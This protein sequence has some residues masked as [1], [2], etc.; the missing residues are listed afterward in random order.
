MSMASTSFNPRPLP[1][2]QWCAGISMAAVAAW[3]GAAY[4][5]ELAAPAPLKELLSEH[6][7]LVRYR[8]RDDIN[9][10]LLAFMIDAA[11]AQVRQLAAT[12]GYFSPRTSVTR[13]RRGATD[14]INLTVQPGPRTLVASVDLAVRGPA[15][16]RSPDQVARL[17]RHWSLPPGTPFRQPAWADAKQDALRTLRQRRYA[18]ARIAGSRAAIN[19]DE[20]Q[21]RLHVTYDSGPPFTFGA[22][23]VSGAVRYPETI[24]ANVNPLRV[25]EQYSAARLIEFQRQLLRLPYYSNVV[26][27]MERDPAAAQGAPVHVRVSEFPLQ[28]IRGGIGYTTDT[29]A[30]VSARHSHNSV[31]RPALVLDTELIVEQRRQLGR[32]ELALAPR[33]GGF[34][35]S[36][37]L[38]AE[39]TRLEGIDQRSRRA[40]VQRARHGERRDTL[41]AL[42]YYRD[43]LERLNQAP[44]PADVIIEPGDHQASVA[45]VEKTWRQVD[46]LVFPRSGYV[47][48]AHAGAALKGLLTDQSFVRGYL[49]VQA[50]RPLRPRDLVLLRAELGL[51]ATKG[52]NGAIPASLLFRGGGTDSVRGYAYQSIG[53]LREGTVY[54]ARSLLTASAEYQYWFRP[55]WGAAL[56]YDTGMAADRWRER[57]WFHGAGAGVR[58]RTPVGRVRADLA[59]GFRDRQL[60]PHLSLGVAF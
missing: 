2:A 22:V 46:D 41:Y 59:Y 3:A 1:L 35:D 43:R 42:T 5:V 9:P 58:W 23:T 49:R 53:N 13:E 57:S 38:S 18:A 51:L 47:M 11:P 34:V 4:E 20:H 6:L 17:H 32:L 8:D 33:P 60:R 45:S 19:A 28:R 48:S 25:G 55:S 52:G 50:Y 39:R 44:L 10:Q 26:I 37:R 7:D 24:V 40:G 12:E 31:L 30:S 21:A 36:A 54:P 27:D 56:F 14:T 16:E 29:G 15:A